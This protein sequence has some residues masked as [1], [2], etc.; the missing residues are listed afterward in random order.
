MGHREDVWT[1]DKYQE[2]L[3]GAL[4]WATREVDAAI[5]PNTSKFT[6]EF[7]TLQK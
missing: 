5:E 7:Q 6:P 4:K 1:N 2:L 3:V